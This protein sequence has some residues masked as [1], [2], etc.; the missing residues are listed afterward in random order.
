MEVEMEVEWR[1]DLRAWVWKE[2]GGVGVLSSKI[3][4]SL[5][6]LFDSKRALEPSL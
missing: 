4:A 2:R 3:D 5:S 1:D 6:L